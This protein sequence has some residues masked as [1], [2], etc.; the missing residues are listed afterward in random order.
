VRNLIFILL[1]FPLLVFSQKI[2][3]KCISQD[4][5]IIVNTCKIHGTLLSPKKKKQDK[6][7]LVIIV[8]GSGPTDRNGN[9][10]QLKNNSLK[11]LAEGL[12]LEGYSSFRY[13]KRMIGESVDTTIKEKDLRFD[14]YINDLVSIVNFFRDSLNYSNIVLAG[15]SEGSLIAMIASQKTK[16]KKF[17]S[18]NGAGYS[19]DEI[20]KKQLKDNKAI[21]TDAYKII[22]ILKSGNKPDT[23]PDKLKVLFRKSVQDYLISWFKY[24]PANE[25]SKLKI[26][27]LIIQGTTDIQVDT[28]D[29]KRL[30]SAY[31]KSKLIIIDGMN[32]IF[33][34]VSSNY[35]ENLKTYYNPELPL[36]KEL[37]KEIVQFLN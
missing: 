6:H 28:N 22:D 20:L 10:P 21:K 1:F 7:T 16:V 14:T 27:A 15:H 17:I 5:E 23:I 36:H 2:K 8:A 34:E 30:H 11:L 12:C 32:H 35:L 37:I 26:P 9:N 4:K 24:D 29:A 19:A 25:I 31:P 3:R 13:D 33:R 18:L